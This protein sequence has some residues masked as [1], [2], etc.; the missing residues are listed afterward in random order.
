VVAV[1]LRSDKFYDS[2]SRQVTDLLTLLGDIGGLKEFFLL[3]GSLFV[4]YLAS[5]MFMSSI[6]RR[7]YQIRRYDNL[8]DEAARPATPEKGNGA[9]DDT[10]RIIDD[11]SSSRGGNGDQFEG[12]KAKIYPYQLTRSNET[13]VSKEER[14]NAE[15]E[16]LKVK[17]AV[18]QEDFKTKTRIEGSDIHSLFFAFLNRQRFVYSLRDIFEYVL[19]CLCMRDT[20]DLRQRS[21]VKRHFLFEKAEEKFSQELDVVRIIRTL[22]RFKMLA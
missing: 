22:R 14:L 7:I 20:G 21:A 18:L 19:R 12:S 10:G 9:L 2:Y 4:N 1:Y 15:L 13:L 8:E 17:E 3:I 6:V 11:E 16:K 5:R